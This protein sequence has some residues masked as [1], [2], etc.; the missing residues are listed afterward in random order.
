[1]D[2]VLKFV[3]FNVNGLNGPIKRKRVL[4]YLKKVKI[5]TA[6]I[7]ETHLTMQEHKK[8]RR[9]WIGQVF[10]SSFNSRARGVAVLI[11]K[12]LPITIQE[13]ITDPLGQYV[14]IHCQ[15]YS[16]NWTL[17][18]L[19]APNYDNVSFI[20]DI[21]LRVAGGHQHLL[22]GGDFNFCLDP[23]L[24]KSADASAQTKTAKT[25]LEFMKD[26]NL[27]RFLEANTPSNQRL[28]LLLQP[29]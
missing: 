1:M 3:S 16:E 17:L 9:E 5:D 27:K 14:L 26:L 21:F 22:I 18:N 10:S 2:R 29:P 7:Q 12:N 6:F 13:T 25:I 24:D 23:V 4:T 8:L 15:I 28:L 19:Y 11:N 20:Q